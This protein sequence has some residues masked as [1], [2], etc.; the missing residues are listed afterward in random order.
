MPT[1]ALEQATAA[2]RAA[3]FGTDPMAPPPPVEPR[4][5][6][7]ADPQAPINAG[8][9]AGH[10]SDLSDFIEADGQ[11]IETDRHQGLPQP[12]DQPLRVAGVDAG[13][14]RRVVLQ[15]AGGLDEVAQIG[16]VAGSQPGVDR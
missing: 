7:P 2:M 8:L 1:T 3:V 9:A 5:A 14:G 13:D 15:Q 6:A 10:P 4:I 11:K 12:P 16:W